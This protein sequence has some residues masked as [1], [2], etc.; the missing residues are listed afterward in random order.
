VLFE[1]S[2]ERAR[3][4]LGAAARFGSSRWYDV[5]RA[6]REVASS[7]ARSISTVAEAR[8]RGRRRSEGGATCA[9][10]PRND[11]HKLIEEC[12]IL[13]N[14]ATARASR[15][16]KR[17]RACTASTRRPSRRS[18]TCCSAA[19]RRSA[20][21]G[22]CRRRVT[23]RDLRRITERLGK[24]LERP[25]VES[26]VMR[27]MPQALYQ[28]TNIGHFGLALVEYAHFTSPI[29]RYPDLVV[30]R[31]LKAICDASDRSGRVYGVDELGPLGQDLSRLEKRADE[32][33]RYVD[34]FL[35]ISYLRARL[36]QT[37][38]G[39]VTTV[40]EFGA[41]VQLTDFAVDG[42]LHLESLRD[43]EYVLEHGGHAWVGRRS[44][45]R[46]ALGTRIRVIV[47]NANPVEGLIDLELD[48]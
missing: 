42:L 21:L 36:G 24:S 28:P 20:S 43:D 9:F 18:S 23:P 30:H 48:V 6:L 16:R 47:T 40:V 37:F 26:L 4:C 12:M 38:E 2:P 31:A 34:T 15:R 45:R 13:A 5:Y 19:S 39:L 29:R 25:I 10:Y 3:R 14:V 8:L 33:D 22:D 7:A 35:K 44:K 1:R 46:L 41:F 17:R 32:A 11:A 27:S